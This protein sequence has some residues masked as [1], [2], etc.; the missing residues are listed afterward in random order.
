[1]SASQTPFAREQFKKYGFIPSNSFKFRGVYYSY[2]VFDEVHNKFT[3]YMYK[4]FLDDI[5]SGKVQPVDPFIHYL[6]SP[7]TQGD[8]L[9]SSDK[10]ER[11]TRNFPMDK[12]RLESEE[13]RRL[14]MEK[15]QQ[16]RSDVAPKKINPLGSVNAVVIKNRD[17]EIEDKSSLYA[18]ISIIYAVS[19]QYYPN[20]KVVLEVNYKPNKYRDY[21]FPSHHHLD[22]ET[23]ALLENLIKHIWYGAELTIVDDSDKYML[24]TWNEWESMSLYFERR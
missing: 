18:M 14:T 24:N 9:R 6:Q 23:I 3:R 15:V 16:F 22:D 11:F 20:H 13:I 21:L 5:A 19:E 2:R 17:D 10:L 1:M 12:F 4:K 8:S 7:T